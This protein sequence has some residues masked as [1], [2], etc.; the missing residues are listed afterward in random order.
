[1][2]SP[3]HVTRAQDEA[4]P[5]VQLTSP[6]SQTLSGGEEKE[7][8]KKLELARD[9]PIKVVNVDQAASLVIAEASVRGAERQQPPANA[10]PMINDY[11]MSARIVVTNKDQSEVTGLGFR[12]TSKETTFYVYYWSISLKAGK[13]GLILINFM[14]VSGEPS[15]LTIQL[16]GA[17]R[18][19]G[20]TW[21]EFPLPS[22]SATHQSSQQKNGYDGANEPAT[23][24]VTDNI[25]Q[26]PVLPVLL[27]SPRPQ[28]TE[29]ARKNRIM[30]AA[31]LKVLIGEDGRVKRVAVIRSLPDFLTE[32][33][34]STA[35]ELKFKPAT[36][37]G[38]AVAFWRS[39]VVDFDLK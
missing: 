16:T 38:K 29:R 22:L 1:L 27:N 12:F 28:Y 5:R 13:S 24:S 4:G 36:I 20:R 6:S 23:T 11:A 34:I 9:V 10:E 26:K 15:S 21:G 7:L 25:A 35:F 30:G 31:L 19:K 32:A 18:G 17:E 3:L 39:M 14:C 2:V 33:A 8:R 37:Q